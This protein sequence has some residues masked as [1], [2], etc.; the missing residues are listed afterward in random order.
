M[1]WLAKGTPGVPTLRLAGRYSSTFIDSAAAAQADEDTGINNSYIFLEWM[2]N[3]LDGMIESKPQMH[4]GTSTW[5]LGL[6]VE[7]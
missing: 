6:A 4:V 7:M 5:V 2:R 3:N 1:A